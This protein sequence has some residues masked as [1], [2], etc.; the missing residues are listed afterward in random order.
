MPLWKA[1]KWDPDEWSKLFKKAGA[2]YVIPVGEHHDGFPLWDSKLTDWNAAKI[3]PKRDLIAELGEA[4]RVRGTKYG[5]SYH[6]LLNY[7]SPEYSGPDPDYLN[8]DYIEFTH[9]KIREIID[10][11]EPDI[12]WLDGD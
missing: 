12:L 11:Y 7:Y 2:K 5:P 3:G 4:V 6:G 1:E 8:E 10:L 9:A